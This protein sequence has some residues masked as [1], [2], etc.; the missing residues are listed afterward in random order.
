MQRLTFFKNIVYFVEDLIFYI[1]LLHFLKKHVVSLLFSPRATC[2]LSIFSVLIKK[3][4]NYEIIL[5]IV[6]K[7][8]SNLTDFYQA[9]LFI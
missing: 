6:I 1:D 8:Y 5:E 7:L 9:F 3:V 4:L 2:C